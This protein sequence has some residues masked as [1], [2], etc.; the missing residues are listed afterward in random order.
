[1]DIIGSQREMR[2]AFL[3]GFAG[4]LISGLIWLIA[5]AA[6]VWGSPQYGMGFLFFGSMFIFP[7]TQA[8]LRLLGRPASASKG[9]G[10]WALGS[11]VAFT[12]PLNFL[13]VGAA[14][15]ARENWFFPAAMIA[16]G[17][18]YLPFVTLYGMKMFYLLAAL[19]VAGGA[20]LA[21]YGPPIFSLGGWL[22][23]VL[24]IVFAI[25]GRQLVLQEEAKQPA[26]AA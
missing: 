25:A 14:T 17:T 19:L 8:L 21:L 7:L 16:V 4:Q 11:Q 22:T 26:R 6:S 9:N 15:L 3:G 10:L 20:G 1:M 2:S 24:L 13:L 23:G 5:A 18:H 12:V